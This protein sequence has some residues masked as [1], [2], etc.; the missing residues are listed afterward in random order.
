MK[1]SNLLTEDIIRISEIMSQIN[2]DFTVNKSKINNLLTEAPVPKIG[3]LKTAGEELEKLLKSRNT[4]Q[5]AESVFIRLEPELERLKVMFNSTNVETALTD[6]INKVA[7]QTGAGAT[8][9]KTLLTKII[10]MASEFDIEYA[11]TISEG[12]YGQFINRVKYLKDPKNI[13]HRTINPS[14][15]QPLDVLTQA[16]GEFEYTFGSNFSDNLKNLYTNPKGGLKQKVFEV[17][18]ANLT[19]LELKGWK[20]FVASKDFMIPGFRNLIGTYTKALANANVEVDTLLNDAFRKIQAITEKTQNFTD[21]TKSSEAKALFDDIITTFTS[22]KTE[23]PVKLEDLFKSIRESLIGEGLD[24]EIANKISNGLEKALKDKKTALIP[25]FL[26]KTSWANA[27]REIKEAKGFFGKLGAYLKR[28]LYF[29]TFGSIK[30]FPEWKSFVL[31]YGNKKMGILAGYLYYQAAA[32]IGL[33]LF[34]ATVSGF[35]HTIGALFGASE[36]T[37]FGQAF[38]KTWKEEYEKMFTIPDEFWTSIKDEVNGNHGK[39][40]WGLQQL[41]PVHTLW[42]EIWNSIITAKDYVANNQLTALIGKII[43]F[44]GEKYNEGKKAAAGYVDRAKERTHDEIEKIK[45]GATKLTV[46]EI[47]K[48]FPCY[49]KN[50][51]GQVSDLK[52]GDRGIEITGINSFSYKFNDDAVPYE[53][54]LKDDGKY[55]WSDNTEFKC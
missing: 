43:S 9:E 47:Y 21:L 28:Q 31:D 1:H 20:K 40:V 23:E 6:L 10:K 14:T 17:D 29:L 3:Q 25:E 24:S 36:A 27:A 53:V 16:L 12:F 52:Y 50:A 11:R 19:P 5:R 18:F 8:T 34:I 22:I 15:N 4:E 49:L 42:P 33:P 55:Y 30:T 45:S 41:L 35:L 2:E 26:G 32:R 48:K 51:Q 37:S 7:L 38:E 39:L 44:I 13:Y 46:D 54:T